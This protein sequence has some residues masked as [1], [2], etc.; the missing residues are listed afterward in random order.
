MTLVYVLNKHGQPLMP[1]TARKAKLLLK[2]NKAKVIQ[3]TPFAIQLLYGSTGYKQ[4]ITLGVDA[5]SQNI[6][7]SATTTTQELFSGEVRLRT[8]VQEKLSTRRE[9]RRTRRNRKTRYRKVRF[10]NRIKNK[11]QGWLPPSI[12]Q[13]ID[14]H[15]NA[16]LKVQK[17]LPISRV[18][19]EVAS[20][21]TQKIKKPDIQGVRYQ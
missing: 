13:K 19:V 7:L 3:R 8:D 14:S 21:D 12:N 18:I 6:G 2:G 15:I 20:F 1:T 17:I 5:G 11:K 16:V 4:E 10:S 9:L